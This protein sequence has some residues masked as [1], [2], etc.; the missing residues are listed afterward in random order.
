MRE[1]KLRGYWK[2]SFAD[3]QQSQ[4]KEQTVTHHIYHDGPKE[5][6]MIEIDQ[7]RELL[8]YENIHEDLFLIRPT[9]KQAKG[10]EIY[11]GDILSDYTQ[12][13]EGLIKSFKQVFWNDF[14]ASYHLDQSRN[15]DKSESRELWMELEEFEYEISGNIFENSELLKQGK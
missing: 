14:T 7:L 15:Q 13:D 10:K 12:T 4:I 11:D 8:V 9:G 3:N 1:L 6:R 2:D 5:K